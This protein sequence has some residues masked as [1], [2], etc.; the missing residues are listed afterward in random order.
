MYKANY[1]VS[2][3]LC[4]VIRTDVERRVTNSYLIWL[5]N[6]LQNDLWLVNKNVV[7][8]PSRRSVLTSLSGIS[9]HLFIKTDIWNLLGMDC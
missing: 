5:G 8:R 7:K 1:T 9:V 3:T 2:Y 6:E 4:F